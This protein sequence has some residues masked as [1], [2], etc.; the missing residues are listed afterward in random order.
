MNACLRGVEK[1]ASLPPRSASRGPPSGA[2]ARFFGPL[3]DETAAVQCSCPTT[4]RSSRGRLFASRARSASSS[5]DAAGVTPRDPRRVL[6]VWRRL[7]VER[8]RPRGG[9]WSDPARGGSD[10]HRR[11]GGAEICAPGLW[12]GADAPPR[13]SQGRRPLGSAVGAG[14]GEVGGGSRRLRPPE[15]EARR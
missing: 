15:Y 3:F 12:E 6:D 14:Q 8:T 9:S 13:V 5:S 4:R 2:S 11:T 1:Q 10:R 7:G